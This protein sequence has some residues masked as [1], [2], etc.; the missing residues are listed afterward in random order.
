MYN[1]YYVKE[2]SLKEFCEILPNTHRANKELHQIKQCLSLFNS[3]INGGEQHS[4]S[5]MDMFRNIM[6]NIL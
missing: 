3:M 4:K 2:L 6:D 5:S 1:S